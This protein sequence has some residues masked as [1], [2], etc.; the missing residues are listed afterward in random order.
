[1]SR[2]GDPRSA[3]YERQ[4]RELYRTPAAVVVA[5][6]DQVTFAPVICDPCCGHGDMLAVFRARGHQALGPD[7]HPIGVPDAKVPTS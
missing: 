4:P 7:I 6:L 3:S 5:L 2:H 1:V